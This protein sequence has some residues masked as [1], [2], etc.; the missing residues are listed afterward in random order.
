MKA[1]KCWKRSKLKQHKNIHN[2][3]FFSYEYERWCSKLNDIE[4]SISKSTL[5]L[6]FFENKHQ[7]TITINNNNYYEK[8]ANS[9]ADQDNEIKSSFDDYE[10]ENISNEKDRDDELLL[11]RMNGNK[12]CMNEN[13][14]SE[15]YFM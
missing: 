3:N 14:Q 6:Y 7:Q 4:Q 15:K 12:F 2:I 9:N 10:N 13:A 1:I 5:N 8:D 11:L